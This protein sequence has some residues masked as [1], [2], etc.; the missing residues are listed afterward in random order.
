MIT[1]AVA[2]NDDGLP[3]DT[4][5]PGGPAAPLSQPNLVK[6][7]ERVKK[8]GVKPTKSLPTPVVELAADT[9]EEETGELA[10]FV[11][12]KEGGTP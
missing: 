9:D 1:P 12:E 10:L 3:D 5:P 11:P 7:A 6:T 8:L 4:T 2:D